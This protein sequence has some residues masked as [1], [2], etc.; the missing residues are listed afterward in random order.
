M[1]IYQYIY[2]RKKEIPWTLTELQN[3]LVKAESI[4]DYYY[5]NWDDFCARLVQQTN[6]PGEEWQPV[7]YY[8]RKKVEA[9]NKGR[10][11]INGKIVEKEGYYEEK[12]G[13]KV[14]L[15]KKWL[16][17]KTTKNKVGYLRVKGLGDLRVYQMVVNAW[18]K[19]KDGGIIH[20][21]TNDGYDNRLENLIIVSETDHY[22]IHHKD[23]RYYYGKEKKDYKPNEIR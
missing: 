18:L 4:N 1:A 16:K 7:P 13:Q 21:I 22:N 20:H 6:L 15:D 17:D 5:D 8:T 11:R 3:S 12:L 23:G 14:D 2:G 10:I 19:C 9:S